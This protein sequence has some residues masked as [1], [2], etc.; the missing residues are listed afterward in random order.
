VPPFAR[1]HD[2][3][4]P[5]L[6]AGRRVAELPTLA[7]TREHA[8]ASLNALDPALLRLHAASTY[9]VVFDAR[10]VREKEAIIAGQKKKAA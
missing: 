8:L 5:V 9:P 2:L 7:R 1:A 10:L 6:R 3:L 4:V